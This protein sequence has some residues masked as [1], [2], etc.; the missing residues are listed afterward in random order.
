MWSVA[1]R[2][3]QIIQLSRL[4]RLLTTQPQHQVS[5]LVLRPYQE[6]CLRACLDAHSVGVSRVG[7]S[8]PT[9]A[10]KTA[11]FISLLSSLEPRNDRP[12]ATRSLVIVNSIELARQAADQ[13]KRLR[14]DW[15]IE[16]EQGSHKASGDADLT[17]ATYQTLLESGRLHKFSPQC[18]KAI[19][20]DEAH[21]AAAPSYRRILSYFHPE[22][23]CPENHTSAR[24][25]QEAVPIFG[26][27]ATF[28]R[29]D[30]L[31]LGS[32]FERIVYHRDFLD[33]IKEQWLCNVRFTTVKANI[34][35]RGVTINTRSGDFSATSLAHVIN[36]EALNKLVVKTWFD[37][38]AS[39]RKS[40]VVFAVNVAHVRELTQTFK[41]A[42]VDAR[43]LHA[44]TPIAERNALIDGFKA[45]AFPVLVNCAL[46]TEGTDIPNIDCVVIARPTRSRN[47]FLQMIGRGMRL[48]SN[49]GKQ[50][51]HVIDFVDSTKRIVGIVNAPT[52]F[53]LAPETVV[54]HASAQDLEARAEAAYREE[55]SV[56]HAYPTGDDRLSVP[57]PKSVTYIDYDNPFTLFNRSIEASS[58]ILRLS[59][60]A[61]VDCGKDIYVL[62]CLR[63][64]H[65]RI[66][67]VSDGEHG[68]TH[69]RAH[70]TPTIHPETASALKISKFRT[71]RK[72]LDA[73]SLAD[74]LRGC[75]TYVSKNV[76][77]GRSSLAQVLLHTA[78]WRQGP[79]SPAQKSFVAKRWGN[80]NKLQD[81]QD[82]SNVDSF[83]EKLKKMTKG[84]AAYIITRLKHGA[85]RRYVK[86][87]V[88]HRKLEAAQEREKQRQ[89]REH[90]RVGPLTRINRA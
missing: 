8:L 58:H 50:D 9:G 38:A 28:S 40:T 37:R 24:P 90:V 74:A 68:E 22:V 67:P 3:P 81:S 31:A 1:P 75:D 26:F 2:R 77:K 46:L 60:N 29:H 42:G 12:D 61:W 7:V 56:P 17:V 18:F 49:T 59:K 5:P 70:Y 79:A 47:V 16:I 20:V 25:V 44:G 45:G 27:S 10:G 11:V 53:G 78:R 72:I 83:P 71:N 36:T 87:V 21:H 35:L 43:Y 41:S 4:V 15:V 52:L 48:S 88:A 51:C 19:V 57:D 65:I 6:K 33:M 84:D 89:A 39:D 13:A 54:D 23:Q 85:Q 32:V 82:P 80:V 62:E 66:E 55:L 30:G 86:K 34:D 14:P 76:L 73:S 63:N 69:F 64:G